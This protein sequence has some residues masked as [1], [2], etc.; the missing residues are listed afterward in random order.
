MREAAN[1]VREAGFEPFM[2]SATATKQQW[3]ADQSRAGLFEAVGKGARWQ[4]YADRLL[5]GRKK[6]A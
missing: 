3:M 1:T 4:D 5:S 2:A 6:G